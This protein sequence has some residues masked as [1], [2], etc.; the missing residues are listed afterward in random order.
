M[1]IWYDIILKLIWRCQIYHKKDKI[2]VVG[3][4][5]L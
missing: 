3:G 5:I 2:D 1:I 4:C